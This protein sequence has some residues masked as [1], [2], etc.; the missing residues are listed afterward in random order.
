MEKLKFSLCSVN[1][2]KDFA[3]LLYNTSQIKK[4]IILRIFCH[5]PYD[6]TLVLLDPGTSQY[7]LFPELQWCLPHLRCGHK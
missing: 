6:K 3:N 7:Y 4:E 2:I 1:I 5:T